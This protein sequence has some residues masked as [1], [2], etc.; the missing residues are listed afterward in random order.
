VIK[1]IEITH[2]DGVF[3]VMLVEDVW[4]RRRERRQTPCKDHKSA[5]ALQGTLI[6]QLSGRWAIAMCFSR[7]RCVSSRVTSSADH[8][9]RSLTLQF[10]FALAHAFAIGHDLP[11]IGPGR[12]LRGSPAQ[13]TMRRDTRQ[14]AK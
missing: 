3:T 9:T 12:G 14:P 13:E 2:A 8:L 6:M 10:P 1:H 5:L 7:S 4:G 11:P